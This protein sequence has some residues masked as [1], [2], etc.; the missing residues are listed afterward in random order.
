[1]ENFE[2]ARMLEFDGRIGRA[3]RLPDDRPAKMVHCNNF[4]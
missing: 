1:M 3:G 4:P 2:A